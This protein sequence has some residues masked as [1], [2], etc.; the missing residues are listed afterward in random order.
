[1]DPFLLLCINLIDT[2][3]FLNMCTNTRRNYFERRT[4]PNSVA[5]QKV[6]LNEKWVW[7]QPLS[8]DLVYLVYV[9]FCLLIQI[10]QIHAR[11][12][13][14]LGLWLMQY[15]GLSNRKDICS[16]AHTDHS[17]AVSSRSVDE[18]DSTS[19]IIAFSTPEVQCPL[20]WQDNATKL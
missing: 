8:I 18:S 15:E 19:T 10:F 9:A 14:I 12:A 3:S 13:R 6:R 4:L 7:E 5:R 1:M 11:N 16:D 2:R 20:H 17:T